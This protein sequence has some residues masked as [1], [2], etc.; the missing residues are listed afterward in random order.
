VRR[1][2]LED[3][4]E[5][6]R[7][8]RRESPEFAPHLADD[9]GRREIAEWLADEILGARHNDHLTTDLLEAGTTREEIVAAVLA[10]FED[11][12]RVLN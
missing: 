7:E 10:G 8:C 11:A 12:G 1:V 3:L 2:A 5:A 4:R 9:K 6:A